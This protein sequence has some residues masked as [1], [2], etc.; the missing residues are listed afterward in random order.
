MCVDLLNVAEEVLFYALDVSPR[1]T[2]VALG[3]VVAVAL[4]LMPLAA[5]SAVDSPSISDVAVIESYTRMAAE[6]HLLLG[7]YSR[8]QWH[9]P[10]PLGFYLLAPFYV[11]SG[12]KN[13]G[14][15]AGAGAVNIACIAF[16]M[17]V[18]VRRRPA[19][20]TI[21]GAGLAL[22]AWRAADS[23]VSPWNPHMTVLPLVAVIVGAADVMAGAAFSLPVVALFAS[24]AGQSHVA[25]MPC[26]LVAAGA[27]AIRVGAGCATDSPSRW[28]RSAALTGL[29]LLVCWALPLY[30]QLV[31]TPHGNVTELWRFF[32]GQTNAGQPLPV[33]VSAWSDMLT[34]VVR[35]DFVVARGAPFVE[36]PVVW[37]EWL[38]I[39]TLAIIGTSFAMSMLRRRA[40]D[41]FD[42][43]LGFLLIATSGVALWSATRI[44]ERVFDHDVYWMVGLGVLNLAMAV[45]RLVARLWRTPA[46]GSAPDRALAVW[47]AL[48]FL[49]ACLAATAP[50]WQ[51]EEVIARSRRPDARALAARVLADDIAEYLRAHQIERPLLVIDEDAWEVA[52]GAILDLQKKGRAVA[53]E[54]GWVVMFTPEMR[55]TG[56]EPA[57]IR[58][59]TRAARE[60]LAQPIELVS[61]H[62]PVL[63]VLSAR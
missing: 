16:V 5:R 40:E 13:A 7:A 37:A 20:A 48:A 58:L 18:L 6:G 10:G 17:A 8:F 43:A 49:A 25:L 22:L 33:A 62:E 15:N 50:V 14:L 29:V 51:M 19:L 23:M 34:G 47:C 26:V 30:E 9:H 63:A 42:A 31:G 39:G 3:L 59:L 11:G 45:D 4:L 1:V 28:R 52:A 46:D 61:D 36:S 53:V 2:R 54:E 27:A 38:A 44:A 24:L 32:V 41:A 56:R 55:A 35:P 12:A 21:V 60:R 57:T